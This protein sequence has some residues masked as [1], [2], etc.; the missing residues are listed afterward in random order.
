MWIRKI[1]WLWALCLGAGLSVY[2][3]PSGNS[4]YSRFGIGDLVPEQFAPSVGMGGLSAAYQ[5]LIHLNLVNPASYGSLRVASFQVGLRGG[6]TQLTDAQGREGSVWAGNLNSLALGF[7]LRN[8]NNAIFDGKRKAFKMGMAFALTPYSRANYDLRETT[9]SPATGESITESFVGTGSTYRLQG[10]WGFKYNNWSGGFNLGYFFGSLNN[11]RQVLFNEDIGNAFNADFTDE[12]SFGGAH[13]R[14]G[15]QYRLYLGD[16]DPN[17]AEG[18]ESRRESIVFGVYGNGNTDFTAI[19]SQT[20]LG[21]GLTTGT[22]TVFVAEEAERA[23][24]LPG[25]LGF[26]VH[27]ERLNKL[28]LGIEYVRSGWQDYLNEARPETLKNSYRL[29][30]GVEYIP[31]LASYN[32]YRDRVHY[33]AGA[34]YGTDPRGG[35]TELTEFGISLGAGLPIQRRNQATSFIDLALEVGRFGNEDLLQQTYVRLSVGFSLNDNSWFL[36]RKF[37]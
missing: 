19:A 6:H 9:S 3:Q 34:Y 22:D 2:A 5:P 31:N 20:Y 7:P 16:P 13:Y 28:R 32:R 17:A 37:N 8:P 18:V 30:A 21:R 36:N 26:G 4:P 25:T 12:L 10:G 29:A 1:S 23:G 15:A 11:Q 27:Y 35:S 14:L 33:R 24:R